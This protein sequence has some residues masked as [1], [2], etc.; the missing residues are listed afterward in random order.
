M[1]DL[2]YL[3]T[4]ERGGASVCGTPRAAGCM[5]RCRHGHGGGPA[6]KAPPMPYTVGSA[7]TRKR[8]R[9]TLG[10]Q[11]E[12]LPLPPVGERVFPCDDQGCGCARSAR[13][14][15]QAVGGAAVR[16]FARSVAPL[17]ALRAGYVQADRP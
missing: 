6:P 8:P 12:T 15:P 16:H 9:L 17:D 7:H 2:R 13:P 5:L 3:P 4:H 10:G 11:G 14:Y 1:V